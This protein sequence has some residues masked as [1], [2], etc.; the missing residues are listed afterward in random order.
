MSIVSGEGTY[1]M[2]ELPLEFAQ[3]TPGFAM[4]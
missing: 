2:N 3:V 4:E 1:P